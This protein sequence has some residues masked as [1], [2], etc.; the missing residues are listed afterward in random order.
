MLFN[1]LS[2]FFILRLSLPDIHRLA[3]IHTHIYAYAHI[4]YEKKSL[5]F[6]HQQQQK[7]KFYADFSSSVDENFILLFWRGDFKMKLSVLWRLLHSLVTGQTDINQHKKKLCFYINVH[8]SKAEIKD[9]P[10]G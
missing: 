5:Y 1:V 7:K 10:R 2:F 3:H 6:Q 8:S 4:N 9:K